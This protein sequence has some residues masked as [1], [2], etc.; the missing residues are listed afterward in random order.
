MLETG[1]T[2]NSIY[3]IMAHPRCSLPSEKAF[4]PITVE[5][6]AG[7]DK[8]MNKSDRGR[9]FYQKGNHDWDRYILSWK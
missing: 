1:H 2:I 6:G 8:K 9:L 7:G 5:G 3:F 4:T